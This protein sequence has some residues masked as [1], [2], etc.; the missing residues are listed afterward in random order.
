M[1]NG[2]FFDEKI[3]VFI[4]SKCGEEKYDKVRKDLRSLMEDTGIVKAYL[5]EERIASTLTAEQ[6]YLYGLDDSDI[7]L[8]LIDNA[9]GVPDGVLKE[10]QRA[11]SHPKKSLYIFCNEK[12]D[13]ST[14]IQNEITGAQGAKYYITKSFDEFIKVG[15]RSLINDI[16]EIYRSYCKGRLIDPEFSKSTGNIEEI[17]AVASESLDKQIFKNI[18]NTKKIISKEILSRTDIKVEKSSDFDIYSSEFLKVLFGQKSIKDFNSYFILS[19]LKKMQSENLHNVVVVRWNA[20]L[21]FWVNDL[22]KSIELENQALEL[23]RGFKLPNWLIQDIL[24]DLRNLYIFDAQSTNR[25]WIKNNAQAELDNETSPLYYPLL[26]RYEKSL[27]EEINNQFEKS[28]MKSPFSINL[29]SNISQYGDYV[30]NIFIVAV[31]N[32]S[33]TQLLRTMDRIKDV[34]FHLCHQ[35]SDWDFRVLLLKTT[36]IK[37]NAK[38]IKSV[39][40]LFNDVYGKINSDDAKKIYEFVKSSPIK[41]QKNIAQLYAFQHLGYYFD[42]DFFSIVSNEIF[43]IIDIWIQNDNERLGLGSSLFDAIKENLNRLDN[44][45]VMDRILLK[46]FEL[47]SIRHYDKSL[48]LLSK[49]NIETISNERAIRVVKQITKLVYDEVSRDKLHNLGSAIISLRKRAPQLTEDLND[50][51]QRYMPVFYEDI[52]S[53]ET[54]TGN[55]IVGRIHIAKSVN[56]IIERNT[57][58]GKNGQYSGFFDNPYKIIEMI[59]LNNNVNLELELVSSI[60][61]SCKDTLYAESQTLDAKVNAMNLITFLRLFLNGNLFDFNELIDHLIKDEANISSGSEKMFLDKT[62]RATIHFSYVMMKLAFNK[63]EIE[64]IVDLLSM[65]SNFEAYEKIKALRTIMLLLENNVELKQ[66]KKV[67]LHFLQFIIGLSNDSNHDV[68]YLATIALLNMITE[69]NKVPI[70][71]KLISIMDYD[72]AYIKSHILALSD[73][74]SATDENSFSFI[75]EKAKVDNHFIIRQR[76][77]SL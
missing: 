36:I 48:D 16:G 24:I 13:V 10:Y 15:F 12:S 33:L 65:Y 37:G 69:Y 28:S 45:K 75:K 42:D 32:G 64:E 14:H 34:A 73:K 8:F 27:Y 5:F 68:R 53:L 26:D 1:E 19:E 22:R 2:N 62:S 67:N 23:A 74:L 70:M 56:T 6:N 40:D 11:K 47:E 4:S 57:T 54:M 17:N 41:Y 43:E 9:D 38:E 39:I 30:S 18:D 52:Y 72:S 50:T 3:K 20:I 7:C 21:C 51:V 63:A 66:D 59:M 61:N 29:G 76:A 55:E 77:L 58:Q 44:N 25:S 35:Y 31:F 49:V 60:I 46:I 71:K